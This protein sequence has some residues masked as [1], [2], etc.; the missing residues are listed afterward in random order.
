MVSTPE[1]QITRTIPYSDDFEIANGGWTRSG[2]WHQINDSSRAHSGVQSWWYGQDTTGTFDNGTANSG[3]LTSPPLEIDA[4]GY[5]L[6]FWYRYQT[7][8]QE[9]H[10]DQRWVQISVDGGVF[11]NVIQLSDDQPDYWLQSAPLDLSQYAGKTIRI[12]FHFASLDEAFNNFNGWLIDDVE[13]ASNVP[14]VCDDPAEPNDSPATASLITYG[15]VVDGFICPESDVD[16]YAFTGS[17]GDRVVIDIEAEPLGSML[18][19]QIYLL[20]GD[21]TSVLAYHDDQVPFELRDSTLGYLLPQNG[22]YF[23][24]VGDW[25][26]P[27]EGGSD[28]FYTLRIFTDTAPPTVSDLLPVSNAYLRDSPVQISLSAQD[29]LSGVSHVEFYWHSNDWQSADW[30]SLGV[31]SSGGDGWNISFDISSLPDQQ[32]GAIYTKV[33][34]WAGNWTG[35]GSW[36]MN[37]DRTP[38]ISSID[39][40]PPAQDTTAVKLSWSASDNIA[41]IASFDLQHKYDLD[42]WQELIAGLSG[43]KRNAW[44]VGEPDHFYSFRLRAIDRAGNVEPFEEDADAITFIRP[45]ASPDAWENPNDNSALNANPINTTGEA[46]SHNFC[47]PF[48]EDWLVFNAQAE[49]HYRIFAV[50]DDPS[51]ATTIGIYGSDGLTL[52]AQSAAVEFGEMSSLDW[53]AAESGLHYL[54]LQHVDGRVAGDSVRYNIWVLEDYDLYLPFLWRKGP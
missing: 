19:S 38:P 27:G 45:C 9:I 20:D 8:G 53:T 41:G 3:D 51:A 18:D 31:D 43:E 28:H 44:F 36:K 29:S 7:E 1:S 40:L 23:V 24:K 26:Y 11:Q 34:D 13:I 32:G 4:P 37:L 48:D 2:Q 22:T 21:G 10:W 14:P 33:Y 25:G 35:H 6:R 30:V 5:Q 39:A 54:R 46:Q 15:S 47:H 50:P 16:Y 42:P 52:I 17:V 12:R 49:R